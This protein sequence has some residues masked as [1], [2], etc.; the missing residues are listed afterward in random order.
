MD[1]QQTLQHKVPDM[2]II[3]TAVRVSLIT[4]LLLAFVIP[5]HGHTIPDDL[6]SF[7]NDLDKL[8]VGLSY[9]AIVKLLGEGE[10]KQ[11]EYGSGFSLTYNAGT[12]AGVHLGFESEGSESRLTNILF[13]DSFEMKTESGI[14]LGMQREEVR[15]RIGNPLFN[16]DITT[17]KWESYYENGF[18]VHVE[19]DLEGTVTNLYKV[20]RSR[21]KLPGE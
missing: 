10:V 3:S 17:R 21:V 13:F 14:G 16:V 18:I 5:S 9:D 8:E 20:D 4:A 1:Q 7:G 12:Y 6:F 11:A 15:K 2:K 19:Y